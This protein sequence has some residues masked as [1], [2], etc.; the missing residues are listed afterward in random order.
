M[1][2]MEEPFPESGRDETGRKRKI[3]GLLA[4]CCMLSLLLL[5]I[6]KPEEHPRLESA[7]QADSLIQQTLDQ[8]RIPPSRVRIQTIRLD[9]IETRK[10]YT[11][12][13]PRGVSRT[14]WH[15]ELDK[16]LRPR[17]VTTPATVRFPERNLQ[18][19]LLYGTNIIRTIR[20]RTDNESEPP[21]GRVTAP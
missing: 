6:W 11:I 8:F 19:H 3:V 2:E 4:V 14:Q 20:L 13:L 12:D 16:R 17:K 18:I 1:E 7:A 21:D 5:L 9:T 10:I 15:Y